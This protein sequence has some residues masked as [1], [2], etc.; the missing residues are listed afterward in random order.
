MFEF[1]IWC[2]LRG[3]NIR[4]NI[5]THWLSMDEWC[6]SLQE[7]TRCRASLTPI[8]IAAGIYN[9]KAKKWFVVHDAYR[10]AVQHYVIAFPLQKPPSALVAQS[11]DV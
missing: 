8:H 10:H 5:G 2:W 7:R 1:A 11:L 9:R 4:L 3:R 6:P